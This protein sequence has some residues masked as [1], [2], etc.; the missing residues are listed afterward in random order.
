MEKEPN[1]TDEKRYA[2]KK[3]PKRRR[4]FALKGVLKGLTLNDTRRFY[5]LSLLL[6][7][8][9]LLLL[10]NKQIL[11]YASSLLGAITLFAVLRGSMRALTIK[12]KW[13]KSLAA[14]LLTIAAIILFLIPLGAI[15]LMLLDL[16]STTS[17]DFAEIWEQARKWNGVIYERFSVNLLS[18]DTV[19]TL[20]SMGQKVLTWLFANLSSLAINSVLMIFLLYYMLYQR[21]PFERAIRELLPFSQNNKRIL[22][23]E[24]KRIIVANAISIPVLAI[25]QAIFAYIGYLFLGVSNPLFFAVLTAF[26]TIIPIVG[27]MIVYVPIA[28]YFAL[29]AEWIHALIM[30][31][32]GFIIIGGVDNVARF[33]LQKWIADIHPL[34]TVFGV[35]F[36]MAVF[37]FWGVIFGPLLISLLFLFLNMYRHDYVPGSKAIPR[38]TSPVK[39][40][41]TSEEIKEKLHTLREKRQAKAKQEEEE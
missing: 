32:Y 25:I 3:S 2:S 38:I 6:L 28:I 1:R 12:Y 9:L 21:E 29:E 5:F 18:I 33:L 36:G 10:F 16:F 22:I 24:S 39:E 7:I 4:D 13:R 8:F 14:G 30:V 11:S 34:I 31:L 37:G 41:A 17:F 23:T 27:T 15:V 20:S 19:K 26:S 35:I 40:S